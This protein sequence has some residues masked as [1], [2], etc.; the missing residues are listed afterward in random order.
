MP[1]VPNSLRSYW[2]TVG[3]GWLVL[4]IAAA[5]YSPILKVP[6]ALAVPLAL[7]FLVE[8]PFYLLPGFA[9]A[10]NRLVAN[11]KVRA[12]SVMAVSAIVPWLIYALATRHFNFPALIVVSSIAVLTCFWYLAF[13]AH[14]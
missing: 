14:P 9:V 12:A 10:R 6:A 13:P 5:V 8:Y 3:V 4:G 2:V 1:A 7:A 11:G